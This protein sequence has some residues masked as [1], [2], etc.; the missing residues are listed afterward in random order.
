MKTY[1]FNTQHTVK[2]N[3]V[4][5]LQLLEIVSVGR[6][7]RLCIEILSSI[8]QPSF[9]KIRRHDGAQWHDLAR[10][11]PEQ[12]QTRWAGAQPDDAK[13]YEADRDALIEMAKQI[14]L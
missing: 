7:H 2:N 13:V 6:T 8:Y 1:V 12:M 4:H 9:A 11:V 5:L 3:E 14:L 10:V